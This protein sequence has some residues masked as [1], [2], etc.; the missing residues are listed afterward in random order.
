MTILTPNFVMPK[1]SFRNSGRHLQGITRLLNQLNSFRS[2]ISTRT[3]NVRKPDFLTFS[4][5]TAITFWLE[6]G[7]AI[8]DL[9]LYLKRDSGTGAFL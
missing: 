6:I 8:V 3:E 4:E 1:Q 7:A 5:G 2:S 9:Q